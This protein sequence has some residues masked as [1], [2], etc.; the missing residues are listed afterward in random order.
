MVATPFLLH[1]I[2]GR[3][4]TELYYNKETDTFTATTYSILVRKIETQWVSTAE[5]V[6]P[7]PVSMLDNI[8]VGKRPLLVDPQNFIDPQAYVRMMRFDKPPD[9]TYEDE[10]RAMLEEEE[11]QREEEKREVEIEEQKLR[12]RKAQARQ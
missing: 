12:K 3:Y 4:V 7:R 10:M 1:I 9:W 5:D 2:A 11:R 6:E 8:K